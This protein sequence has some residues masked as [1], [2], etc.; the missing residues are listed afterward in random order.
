MSRT[1][2]RLRFRLK[3]PYANRYHHHFHPRDLLDAEMSEFVHHEIYR[4]GSCFR[5]RRKGIRLFKRYEHHAKR[6]RLKQELRWE[7][8]QR[9]TVE[10]GEL[11]GRKG[12]TKRGVFNERPRQGRATGA[13]DDGIAG[14]ALVDI[15]GRLGVNLLCDQLHTGL[16]NSIRDQ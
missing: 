9:D 14:L 2:R 1:R 5:Q 8:D 11:E 16:Q 12:T 13:D 6:G 15:N 4:N 3:Q 10:V 7:L